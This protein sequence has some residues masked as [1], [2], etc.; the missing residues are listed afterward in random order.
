MKKLEDY[1]QEEIKAMSL[2]DR[3][4]LYRSQTDYRL[5]RNSLV[6]MA[7]DGRSFSKQIKRRCKLPFDERFVDMMNKT[8][9]YLCEN[10]QG[11]KIAYTQSDEITIFLTDIASENTGAFFDYRLCKMNSIAAAMAATFFSREFARVM[12]TDEHIFE[13]DCRSWTVPT[14]NDVFA[15]FLWRNN[16]CLRN[17]M[18]QT[19]QTYLPHKRLLNKTT[20]EQIAMLKEE[21][22]IDWHTFENGLK[23]GRFIYREKFPMTRE[24]KGEVIEF[25]RNKWTAHSLEQPLNTEEGRN[26]WKE[27]MK[28]LVPEVEF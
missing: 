8:A 17:S 19:A 20:E 12:G 13:F 6:M 2:E 25:E 21:K 9:A 26:A 11:A 16:D 22:G 15:Y 28:K 5:E 18:G 14:P 27:L 23:F 7:A 24:Y 3:M 10:I 4:L 1:T